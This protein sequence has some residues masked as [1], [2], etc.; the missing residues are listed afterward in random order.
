MTDPAFEA[1]RPEAGGPT[2]PSLRIGDAE[3]NAAADALQQ[4][5]VAGRLTQA[6][7]AAP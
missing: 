2:R 4:H 1:D 3:R 7:L 6:H 5:L